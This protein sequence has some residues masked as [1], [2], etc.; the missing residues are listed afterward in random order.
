MFVSA[1]FFG[2]YSQELKMAESRCRY[3]GAAT[4]AD[5]QSFEMKVKAYTADTCRLKIETKKSALSFT[6]LDDSCSD[7]C[8]PTAYKKVHGLPLLKKKPVDDEKY[9]RNT[10]EF[11]AAAK[12]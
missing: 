3:V 6:V 12:L 9:Y 2:P 5:G 11:K 1:E 8:G 7:F 10:D 4:S